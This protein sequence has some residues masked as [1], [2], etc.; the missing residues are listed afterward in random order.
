MQFLEYRI[1]PNKCDTQL[2]LIQVKTENGGSNKQ[3]ILN[4]KQD[5]CIL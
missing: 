4:G 1:E 5:K 3:C 2:R